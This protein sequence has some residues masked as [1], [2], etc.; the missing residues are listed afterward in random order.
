MKDYKILDV[1]DINTNEFQAMPDEAQLEIVTE[2]LEKI[3]D[4]ISDIYEQQDE[5]MQLR[6]SINNRIQ[7]KKSALFNLQE[8]S[9]IVGFAKHMSYHYVMVEAYVI[10]KIYKRPNKLK[11]VIHSYR[12]DDGGVSYSVSTKDILRS[13]IFDLLD[14]FNVCSLD[15]KTFAELKELMSNLEVSEQEFAHITDYFWSNA[16]NQY[17]SKE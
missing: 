13:G 12:M 16:A 5:L 7:E 17:N 2:A 8:G 15:I 6:N 14:E 1:T 9:I 3:S 4:T 10:K 11:V